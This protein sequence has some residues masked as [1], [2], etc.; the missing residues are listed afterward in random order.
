MG[1]IFSIP[2]PAV[3]VSAAQDLWEIIAPVGSSFRLR[4]IVI[5]Q[6]SDP[7]DS[8]AEILGLLIKKA[9]GTYTSGSG[10][11]AGGVREHNANSTTVNV[12]G[13][14]NNTTQASAGSGAL[15][16]QRAEAVNVQV[17]YKYAPPK[18][19]CFH[20]GPGEACVIS[21][22]APVDALTVYATAVVETFVAS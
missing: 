20:Y 4:E 1:R 8:A 16:T 21:I 9:S 10:G 15:V 11:S 14:I 7:G 2:I 13:E 19:Q 22:T 17:G 5:G 18:D 3:A 12:S 6:I